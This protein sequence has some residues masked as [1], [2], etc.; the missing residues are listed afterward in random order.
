MQLSMQCSL[1]I[2]LQY[3]SICSFLEVVLIEVILEVLHG[4]RIY[5][6]FSKLKVINLLI[7][8]PVG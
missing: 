4:Q 7:N 8:V 3:L 1:K 6:G 2:S 5:I